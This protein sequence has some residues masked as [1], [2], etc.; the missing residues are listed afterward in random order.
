MKTLTI[1]IAAY[2]CEKTIAK[3]LESLLVPEIMDQLEIF[4]VDD[5]G[6][7]GTLE[8][9]KKYESQYPG[10]VFAVHK[11][12]G[13]HGSTINYSIAHATGRYFKLLDGDDWFRTEHMMDFIT[14]LKNSDADIVLTPFA[15]RY[16]TKALD[17]ETVFPM[18]EP[19]MEYRFEDVCGAIMRRLWMHAIAF[20]TD[21]LRDCRKIS[22]HCFYVDEEY[23]WRTIHNVNTLV[24]VPLEIYEY[25]MGEAGQSVSMES[26]KKNRSM[27]FSVIMNLLDYYK[28]QDLSEKK[29]AVLGEHLSL[30]CS[31]QIDVYLML[32]IG[33]DAQRE[34]LTFLNTIHKEAPAV[35]NGFPHKKANL[36]RICPE[37]LY[38][39]L[40]WYYHRYL[41][42]QEQ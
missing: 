42:K 5:G 27:Y 17:K 32:S 35:Y 15:Q 7:D 16:V 28:T 11:E 39:P 41:K 31:E 13:G 20:R 12:N 4:V 21:V 25:S 26:K 2:N 40:A 36:L 8:I 34:L 38:W 6:K 22:E 19:Y 9:A 33:K 37:V 1:S 30:I 24:Y 29:K 23:V 14:F 3:A 18:L 10:V